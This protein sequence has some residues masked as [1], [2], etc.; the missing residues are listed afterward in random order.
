MFGDHKLR[1]SGKSAMATVVSYQRI[2]GVE[3]NRGAAPKSLCK[4]HLRVEPD[5]EPAFE[6]TTKA[7][8][9]GTEGTH[10][11][12]VVPVLY[13][14]SDHSELVIDQSD[15]AWKAAVSETMRAERVA[16]AAARGDDPSRTAAVE[17]MRRAAASDPEGFRRLM[18]E[19]GPAAFGLPGV[20]AT[21]PGMVAPT[22]QNPL[23]DLSKLADLHDRGVLTDAEFQTQKKKLLGE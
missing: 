8:L 15:A 23:D 19:Q 11:G 21:Y 7:W 14:P 2:L 1:K 4:L 5:G 3:E 22:P 12:M 13:D 9:Q 17:E 18:R 6:A 16:R 20:P 10:E